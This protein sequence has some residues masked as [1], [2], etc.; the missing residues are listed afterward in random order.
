MG[1]CLPAFRG[2]KGFLKKDTES[3]KKEKSN[4][5]ENIKIREHL[6]ISYRRGKTRR[7]IPSATGSS[8]EPTN[9]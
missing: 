7:N 8:P 9:V 2:K 1:A 4:I 6:F 3:Q 5:H